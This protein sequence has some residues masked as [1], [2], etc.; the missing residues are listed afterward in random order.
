MIEHLHIEDYAVIDK[1]DLELGDG[2]NI[3]TGETGAGKSVIV[4]AINMV[5]GERVDSEVIRTGADKAVVEAVLLVD[6]SPLALKALEAA[7]LEAEDGR[8]I[9]CREIHK[10]GRSQCRIN[11]R[12]ATIAL[13]KEITDSLVDIHGQHEHQSILR[14]ESHIEILDNWC[15]DE[16]LSLRA[17]VGEKF[18]ILRRLKDELR[19]LKSEEQE[20]ARNIDIYRFQIDEIEKA[21]LS[22]GEEEELLADKIRLA[23]AER[24]HSMTSLA[25]EAIGNRSSECC[26][27]DKLGEAVAA[28]EGISEVD[29]NLQ[30]LVES[31]KN[32]LYQIEDIARELRSYRDSIEFNPARLE[33]I[34][35]RIDLIRA[36]K[37]K[38]GDTEQAVIDY[39]QQLKSK[40]E[41]LANSEERSE[42][43]VA[44]IERLESEL[45]QK[46]KALSDLRKK[47]G[48]KFTKAIVSE[49]VELGMPNAVFQVSQERKEI[50]SLGIDKI[51]FLFSANTGE[52]P[53][54]L[55]KI[56]SGGE[57]SRVM[58]AIKSVSATADRTPTLIFDEIDVGIGGR[59]A[60][61][62]GQKLDTLASKSQVICITHLPQIACRA[63][64]HFGIEKEV[65]GGRTV[66]RVR[67]LT[68]EERVAEL[69]RMLGGA[70]PSP[71]AIQHAREMLAMKSTDT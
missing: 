47:G 57:I 26:A 32:A 21:A 36:L 3:L 62:I 54:P 51:E 61:V 34:Q 66:V 33:A 29:S 39:A 25:Y 15:G 64:K 19:Q 70:S 16:V 7:G 43:L 4:D 69:S 35:E 44:E 50:D 40:L 38:Y 2:L 20:R 41:L 23:N 42:E 30:P 37:R 17:E 11:G 71:T 45:T 27:L 55:V 9:I 13:L 10:S 48:E 14:P 58:L 67:P 6:R 31:L 1:L 52:P 8:I 49:L 46:A 5:L 60:E 28:L 22:P 12:V 18:A 63:G 56:A 53:K 65:S 68:Y 24:L 59:T